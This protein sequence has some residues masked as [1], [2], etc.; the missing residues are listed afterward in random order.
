MK[1]LDQVVS[2]TLR[3]WPPFPMTDRLCVKDY[4]YNDGDRKLTI[5]KGTSVML[6]IYALH[7]DANY[8]DEPE[9]F[10]PDRFS[11]VNK[12]NIAACTYL[13]FGIGPRNC[14]RN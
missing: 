10:N 13:S 1:Y 12:G 8:F 14:V 6:P 4:H 5:E 9:K 7:H 11:D 2:E 3:K